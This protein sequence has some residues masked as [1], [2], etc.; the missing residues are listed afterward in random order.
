MKVVL[1]TTLYPP[2]VQ[3]GAE[4]AAAL[5]AEALVQNGDSVAVITL[6][7]G[8]EEMREERNGVR[9]YR[10]PLDNIY[11]PFNADGRPGAARRL[12]WH[13]RDLWN[14]RA[15]GRVAAILD[16][17]TPD[18]MHTHSIAGF[19]IAVWRAAERRGIRVVHTTHDYYLLCLRSDMFRG[20]RTCLGRCVSCQL[21]RSAHRY[22]SNRIDEIVSVSQFVLQAHKSHGYFRDVSSRVGNN[23]SVMPSIQTA[24]QPG[25]E[26]LTFGFIG[27]LEQQKGIHILLSACSLLQDSSW[28]LRIAGRGS[29]EFVAALQRQFPD[30]RIAWLG[31]TDAA[32][33]YASV[34][35]VVVPSLWADPLPYV[36]IETLQAGKG[37]I[38]AVSGGIPE[39]AVLGR[40]V[41][42]CRPNDALALAAA[43]ERALGD[44]EYWLAGGFRD[45]ETAALFSAETVAAQHRSIYAR[46]TRVVRPLLRGS[47]ASPE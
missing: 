9:V 37:L 1:V 44:V 2:I 30:P 28:R 19:S 7:P 39:I 11:W 41:T 15:A 38:S 20:G 43:M 40:V 6:H 21:G 16:I 18:V 14:H 10:L 31:Y 24:A 36:A 26:G 29:P 33:F 13:L 32:S 12:V 22:W 25:S 47:V 35:V 34:D 17:E 4:K 5:L 27:R 42:S 8:K 23:V 45:R 46:R 3:G